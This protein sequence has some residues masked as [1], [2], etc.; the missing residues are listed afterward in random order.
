ML[1]TDLKHRASVL[2]SQF[3]YILDGIETADTFGEFSLDYPILDYREG[4]Y[5]A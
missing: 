4:T 1:T 2:D 5:S 3:V